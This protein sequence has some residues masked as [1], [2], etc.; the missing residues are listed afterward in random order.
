MQRILI[1]GANRGIGL[2]LVQEYLKNEET[3]IFATCRN[4]D[5]A[6]ELNALA[7]V[8]P[9]QV[10]VIPLDVVNQQSVNSSRR[11]V[12]EAVK[13]LDILINNAGILPG[14]VDNRDRNI[15]ALGQLE[16]D[17]MLNV[18]RVN[19]ISPVIVTQAFAD[20]L[21]NG[22]FARVINVSSDAGSINLRDKGCDYSYPS[23]KAALNMMS[24]C[25][26]GDLHE[27]GVCVI[28][29]HPGWIQ[30]D[31][32][33]TQALLTLEESIPTMVKVINGLSLKDSGTFLNWDG[34]SV[35]W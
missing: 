13:G 23:S 26:A 28:S 33:G 21:R 14:G 2:A 1:T 22:S 35:A 30:T 9:E 25:L 17:A 10:R 12:G 24:R 34:Q 16:A 3:F 32:G 29:I 15:S 4:P 27:D 8:T 31:M 18:F 5:A 6:I 11:V 19:T 20:L 7:E